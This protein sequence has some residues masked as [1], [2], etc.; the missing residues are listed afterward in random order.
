MEHR[1]PLLSC[2]DAAWGISVELKG[3]HGHC[4][5]TKWGKGVYGGPRDFR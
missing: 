5:M 1:R 4:G 3:D 2:T